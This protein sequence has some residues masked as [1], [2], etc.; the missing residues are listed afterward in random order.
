MTREQILEILE[1]QEEMID[2]LV[3]F[4]NGDEMKVI[5]NLEKMAEQKL[6]EKA[7]ENN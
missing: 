1:I 7:N 2:M 3:T 5:K 6:A 4:N